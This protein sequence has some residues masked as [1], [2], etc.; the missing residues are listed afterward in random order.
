MK[1]SQRL[2]L[3][4]LPMPFKL[5]HALVSFVPQLDNVGVTAY[6]MGTGTEAQENST[7]CPR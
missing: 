6:L 1:D 3:S 5:S 2:T 7:V 4:L